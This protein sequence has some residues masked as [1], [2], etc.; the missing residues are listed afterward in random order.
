M[1]DWRIVAVLAIVLYI[2]IAYI[3]EVI[4]ESHSTVYNAELGIK[5][6]SDKINKLSKGEF[7]F[8]YIPITL[9]GFGLMLIL[10]QLL[11]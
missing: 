8:Q 7:F 4:L 10:M 5:S 1:N 6:T 9:G 3:I 2:L 11:A